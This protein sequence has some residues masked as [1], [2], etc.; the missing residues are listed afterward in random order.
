VVISIG[1][2]GEQVREHVR[3]GA[4]FR[5]SVT[6]IDDGDE[7]RGTAGALRHALDLEVLDEDFAV[8]YGDSYVPLDLPQAFNAFER[9]DLPALMTVFRNES[10]WEASNVELTGQ[11]I[12]LYDKNP[13][14]GSGRRL[15]WIDAGLS[16]FSSEVIRGRVP[17]GQAADLSAICRALSREGALAGLEISEPYHEIGSIPGLDRFER[18]LCAI[19]EKSEEPG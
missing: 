6:Y 16:I 17:P 19:A 1:Y 4:R 18:Y 15:S 5:L 12:T 9:A 14:S 7:R 3:T 8:L 11:R 10:Q 13:P 2:R